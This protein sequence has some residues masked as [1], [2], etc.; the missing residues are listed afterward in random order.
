MQEVLDGVGYEFTANDFVTPIPQPHQ[1]DGL[2][3]QGYINTCGLR[4]PRFDGHQPVVRLAKMESDASL[5]PS[6]APEFVFHADAGME[7]FRSSHE[8]TWSRLMGSMDAA[9]L[10]N[11]P[12][13]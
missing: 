9:S 10:R 4:K 11:G 5:L 1:I 2:A 6:L 8:Q 13:L 3:A 7:A 12:R